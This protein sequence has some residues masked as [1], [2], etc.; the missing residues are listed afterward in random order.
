MF[1]DKKRKM[2]KK[3][4]IAPRMEEMNLET[5]KMEITMSTARIMRP[6]G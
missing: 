1:I 4:Y 6:G 3:K 5:V 2:D